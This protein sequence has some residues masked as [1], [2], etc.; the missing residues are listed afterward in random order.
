MKKAMPHI[1]LKDD[2][3]VDL[4]FEHV[5]PEDK[6]KFFKDL[7]RGHSIEAPNV[8]PLHGRNIRNP[9][10]Y[11]SEDDLMGLVQEQFIRKF[12]NAPAKY[13]WLKYDPV[14]HRFVKNDQ[15]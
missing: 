6:K 2:K 13:P 15:A 10:Q 4:Y 14:R 7:Q 3:A 8:G 1:L 9:T 12:L 5:S 11:F